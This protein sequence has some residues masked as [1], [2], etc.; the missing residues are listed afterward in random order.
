[1]TWC[2]DS[3]PARTWTSRRWRKN[4]RGTLPLRRR[5]EGMLET[6]IQCTKSIRDTITDM[7]S[8]PLVEEGTAELYSVSGFTALVAM[9]AVN[10]HNWHLS[11]V[12]RTCEGGQR[13]RGLHPI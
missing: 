9:H 3:T 13:R 2:P 12:S 6:V 5:G 1:M 8:E 7:L 11:Q 10:V 4:G